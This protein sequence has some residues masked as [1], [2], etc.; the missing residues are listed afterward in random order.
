MVL[1]GNPVSFGRTSASLRHKG[2]YIS[3]TMNSPPKTLVKSRESLQAMFSDRAELRRYE[4]FD[5]ILNHVWTRIQALIKANQVKTEYIINLY[6]LERETGP[7][8][9]YI[10]EMIDVLKK[11]YPGVDFTY[12][13]THGYEGTVL[14][15][16]IIMDWSKGGA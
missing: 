13:E 9:K 2:Q 4:A 8:H 5:K 12:R 1:Q 16:L 3:D 15:R 10:S 7:T 11:E 6:D 14:E